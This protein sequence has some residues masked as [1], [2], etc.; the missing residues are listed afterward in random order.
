MYHSPNVTMLS[1]L[2]FL[3]KYVLCICTFVRFCFCDIF[4]DVISAAEETAVDCHSSLISRSSNDFKSTQ[5]R[6]DLYLY[7]F[8]THSCLHVYETLH[9]STWERKTIVFQENNSFPQ[10]FQ[11]LSI[12][13]RDHV[14]LAISKRWYYCY[15]HYWIT[16]HSLYTARC[17][18]KIRQRQLAWNQSIG[19]DY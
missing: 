14:R 9:K 7:T 15:L 1:Y 18:C 17:V 13:P 12:A 10:I 19:I 5:T 3:R 4:R 16:L 2:H 11:I 6:F 8:T